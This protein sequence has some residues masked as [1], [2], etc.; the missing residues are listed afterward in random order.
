MSQ[1]LNVFFQI[2]SSSPTSVML[3]P[4]RYRCHLLQEAYLSFLCFLLTEHLPDVVINT[5]SFNQLPSSCGLLKTKGYNSAVSIW[6]SVWHRLDGHCC[7][8]NDQMN[9][10]TVFAVPHNRHT[11]SNR[12]SY[13][14]EIKLDVPVITATFW[15]ISNKTERKISI[16]GKKNK[17]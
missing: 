8:L 10:F 6:H 1:S 3:G 11:S 17:D 15:R 5:A 14:R 13:F 2:F 9:V 16:G 4:H 12:R 7:L